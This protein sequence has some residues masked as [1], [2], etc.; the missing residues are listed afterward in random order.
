[1]TLVSHE[2]L[3]KIALTNV[4][5]KMVP[6][7]TRWRVLRLRMEERP[8]ICRIAANTLNKQSRP[9]EKGWSLNWGLGELVTIHHPKK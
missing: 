7:T 1:M 5:D 8:R 3:K 6:V 4:H 2:N 9:A